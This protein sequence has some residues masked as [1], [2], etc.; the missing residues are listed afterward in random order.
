MYIGYFFSEDGRYQNKMYFDD[1]NDCLQVAMT[2]R[3]LVPY[4]RF[5]ESDKSILEVKAGEIIWPE[6][7][8]AEVN[9]LKKKFS[10]MPE[11]LSFEEVLHKYIEIIN[12]YFIRSTAKK[13]FSEVRYHERNLMAVAARDKINLNQYTNFKPAELVITELMDAYSLSDD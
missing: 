5:I 3:N 11:N 4:I 2:Y 9:S 13:Y 10:P 8:A 1:I 6:L 12:S 7:L